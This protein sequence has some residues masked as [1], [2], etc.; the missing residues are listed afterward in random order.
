MSTEHMFNS[1]VFQF[2]RVRLWGRETYTI[3]SSI[4]SDGNKRLFWKCLREQAQCRQ[5]PL[6]IST[7]DM[8]L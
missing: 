7:N 4:G 2:E 8:E 3:P 6:C 1:A 5:D